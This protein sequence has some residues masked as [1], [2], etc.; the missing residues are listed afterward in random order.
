MSELIMASD[1]PS[2]AGPYSPGLVVGDWIFLSGQGGFDPDTGE[3]VSDAIADQTTRAFRNVEVLLRAA[4]ASLD[5]VVSCL[6]HLRDLAQFDEFNASYEQ[7]F[8]SRVKPVRTTVGCDLVAGMRV[9]VTVVARRP[10][11]AAGVAS[12]SVTGRELGRAGC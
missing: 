6:V 2:A 1:A 5:D 10:G 12:G 7:Q 8:P 3:L 9:E 4:G 11:Q